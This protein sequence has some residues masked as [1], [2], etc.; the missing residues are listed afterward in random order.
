MNQAICIYGSTELAAIA[1][2]EHLQQPDERDRTVGV[3]PARE[4]GAEQHEQGVIENEVARDHAKTKAETV[5]VPEV[6]TST[7]ARRH[8]R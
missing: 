1:Q 7:V 2:D 5:D 4:A 6:D 8:R 3:V